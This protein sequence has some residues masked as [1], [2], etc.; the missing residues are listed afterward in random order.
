MSDAPLYVVDASIVARWYLPSPPFLDLTRAVRDDYRASRID[1]TASDNL[2]LEVGGA[3]HLAMR[4]GF[5]R[6]E[7]SEAWYNAFLDWNL[8]LIETVDLLRPA[9]RL[10][11]RFGC[12]FYDAIY[13]VLAQQENAPFI[14]AD[15]K[16]HHALGGRFPLELW[17]EDYHGR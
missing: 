17:I 12:S 7:D 11:L 8:P 9:Y 3:L 2:R 15:Q 13:L 4:A 14:H 16:L 1:L 6:A 10:S 5:I